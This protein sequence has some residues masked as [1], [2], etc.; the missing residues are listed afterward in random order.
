MN[1]WIENLWR[2]P[3]HLARDQGQASSRVNRRLMFREDDQGRS[4]LVQAR[5]HS[6]GDLDSA[7]QRQPNVHRI[8][9]LVRGY[10]AFYLVDDP[11]VRRDLSKGQR[12]CGSPQPGQMLAQFENATVVEAK[13]L[14]DCI[15]AL[16]DRI[17]GTD[18][19]FVPVNE[20]PVDIHQQV[21]VLFVE[22]LQHTGPYPPW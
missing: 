20:P 8:V 10:S 12:F 6:G 11:F 4:A 14:P 16:H 2:R 13:T 15:A 5:I 21:A 18:S 9:H 1:P 7:R 3:P 19:G 17:E 22:L